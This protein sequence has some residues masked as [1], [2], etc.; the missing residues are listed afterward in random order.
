MNYITALRIILFIQW[1]YAGGFCDF[2]D[3]LGALLRS[4][5][6]KKE[7][8]L[9]LVSSESTKV[10][11]S[12]FTRLSQSEI[13]DIF[14]QRLLLMKGVIDRGEIKF[15]ELTRFR[16]EFNILRLLFLISCF[17]LLD[18]DIP[19]TETDILHVDSAVSS[20]ISAGV[21]EEVDVANV[22]VKLLSSFTGI[23]P[24]SAR[25]LLI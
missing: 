11:L 5:K 24:E 10:T 20:L 1:R 22:V 3:S 23:L 19:L 15:S 12:N 4:F 17:G 2:D 16:Q 6:F 13:Q 7:D 25:L 9:P 18:D 21:S 8:T 14:L